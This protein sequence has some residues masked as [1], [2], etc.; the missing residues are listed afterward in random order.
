[1]RKIAILALVS[2][3]A[4]SSQAIAGQP[5]FV[6]ATI[7]PD[8][9]AIGDTVSITVEF[10]GEAKDVEKVYL[11]VREYPQR[12]G[13]SMAIGTAASATNTRSA[14]REAGI[15]GFLFTGWSASWPSRLSSGSPSR[16]SSSVGATFS[17]SSGG[18]P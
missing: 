5:E 3:I 2:L 17:P 18:V 8:V 11:T 14:I 4:L 9:A 12:A 16:F 1:M 6:E 10:T 15:R 7:T 13:P